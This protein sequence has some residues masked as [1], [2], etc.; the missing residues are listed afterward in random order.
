MAENVKDL[1]EEAKNLSELM[2]DLS[3]SAVLFESKD[4]AKEVIISYDRLKELQERLYMHLFAASRGK[5][6]RKFVSI[7]DLIEN[8]ERVAVAAKN[9]SELVLEGREMH[10]VIKSALKGSDETM[11]RTQVSGNSVLAG[12]VIGDLKI[13]T[14]TG[15]QIIAIRRDEGG[16]SKWV[17]S[18]KKDTVIVG[19]DVII[20]VGP[21][22]ACDKLRKLAEG[23][24]K[25]L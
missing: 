6:S 24:L 1:I 16:R 8:A 14:Q 23:V 20:A 4:I 13:R 5:F 25:K 3:Y 18:P 2:L 15:A 21:K 11:V 22:Q 9:M 19:N 17:F 12:Q 7:I 10:P